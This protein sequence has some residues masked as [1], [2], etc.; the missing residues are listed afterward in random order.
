MPFQL[1]N[2]VIVTSS[3]TKHQRPADLLGNILDQ[4]DLPEIIK[5][6]DPGLLTQ[7]IRHVGLDDS[8]PLV[9][10]T[11]QKQLAEILDED[12]WHSKT[13]GRVETFNSERFGVWLN[14]MMENGP[15][16]T[17]EKVTAMDEDLLTLGIC[18]LVRVFR[19][20]DPATYHGSDVKANHGEI[21]DYLLDGFLNLEF[22]GYRVV[23]KNDACWNAVTGLLSELNESDNGRLVRLLERCCRI[24]E[25]SLETDSGLLGILSA[26]EMLEEDVFS[27]R[28]DRK[29]NRGFVTPSAATIF[30][31]DARSVS[32]SRIIADTGIPHIARAYFKSASTKPEED[33]AQRPPA[34]AEGAP[35][36]MGKRIFEFMDTLR[37]AEVLPETNRQKLGFDGFGRR[38]SRC[39]L[40]NTMRTLNL[41]DP[42]LYSQRLMELSFLSNA[43][44]SGCAFRNRTFHPKESAE[45]ALSVCNLGSEYLLKTQ[46]VPE[47]SRPAGEPLLALIKTTHLVYLFRIGWKILFDNVILATA[48]SVSAFI[49]RLKK[50]TSDPEQKH[51]LA[52]MALMLRHSISSGHPWEFQDQ[53]DYLHVFLD[54]ETVAALIEL[55]REYPTFPD[56]LHTNTDG[57]SSPFISSRMQIQSIRR[58]LGSTFR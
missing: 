49:I 57:G 37:K 13:P 52:R 11:T 28:E 8:A 45:A 1:T 19:A 36:S 39:A 27:E 18:R 42:E 32:L 17:A 25:E 55:I 22:P 41:S 40:L 33:A 58:F 44:I 15:A 16:F 53:M 4:P 20:H 2:E 9:F 31:A 5:S 35:G 38:D 43:L 47:D 29:E 6:L 12:L 21:S 54:G 14:V 30:L 56:A 26:D 50:N 10:H 7:L 51:I 34:A 23:S 3:I 24:C 48:E 46:A